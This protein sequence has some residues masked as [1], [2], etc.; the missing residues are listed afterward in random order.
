MKSGVKN[1][2]VRVIRKMNGTCG[3]V[4]LS[5][6]SAVLHNLGGTGERHS[7]ARSSTL[8]IQEGS[9]DRLRVVVFMSGILERSRPQPVSVLTPKEVHSTGLGVNHSENTH[10]L[11]PVRDRTATDFDIACEAATSGQVLASIRRMLCLD[12]QLGGKYARIERP[13]RSRITVRSG[14]VHSSKLSLM[15]KTSQ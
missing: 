15:S 14:T 12:T 4:F 9:T 10:Q 7:P 5:C 11:S 13:S 8:N 3:V 6:V 2:V 1:V